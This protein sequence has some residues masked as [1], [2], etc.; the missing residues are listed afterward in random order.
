MPA[1]PPRWGGCVLQSDFVSF[2]GVASI[3][4]YQ[5]R[6]GSVRSPVAGVGHWP[7]WLASEF[8]RQ[9]CSGHVPDDAPERVV[10]GAPTA[11]LTALEPFGTWSF[12]KPA[13][14]AIELAEEGFP[15]FPSRLRTS[16]GLGEV[17]SEMSPSTRE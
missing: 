3:H 6:P 5:I 8:F 4:L 13:S 16:S 7:L 11:Y 17:Q 15:M 12:G 2:G 14:P 10:P 9:Q 1:S